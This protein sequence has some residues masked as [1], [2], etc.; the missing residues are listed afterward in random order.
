MGQKLKKRIFAPTGR[1]EKQAELG[2]KAEIEENPPMPRRKKQA[3]LGQRDRKHYI[4]SN[5][6]K[7][8]E[9]QVGVTK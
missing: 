6:K 3:E 1:K 8:R 2:Q 5:R 7:R 4:C 9:K